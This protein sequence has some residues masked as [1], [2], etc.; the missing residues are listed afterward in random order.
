LILQWKSIEKSSPVN[1]T[2]K[3]KIL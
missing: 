2:F 3:P 1:V